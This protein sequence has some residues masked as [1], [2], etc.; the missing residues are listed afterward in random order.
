MM[1][2]TASSLN[3]LIELLPLSTHM[4]ADLVFGHHKEELNCNC[5]A[6]TTIGNISSF[7]GMEY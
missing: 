6:L 4:G 7:V 1:Q 2:G 5:N 3:S